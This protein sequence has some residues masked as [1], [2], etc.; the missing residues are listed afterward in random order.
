MRYR[1]VLL[2]ALSALLLVLAACAP[3]PIYK[4]APNAVAATPAQVASSPERYAGGPVI[5]G[6][7]IVEVKNLADHS[8]IQV[9]S[10]PLDNS[11]RP[12]GGHGDSSG[13]GRFIALV[14]GY[15]EAMNYPAGAMITISG[16]L[17]GSRAGTVGEAS[18]V[19]PLVDAGQSHVWTAE[20]MRSGHPNI[21]F[22]VGVGVIR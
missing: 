8:E 19:F 1:L 3:A 21:S 6:G 22:G 13:N 11:Q 15:V 2:P 20:E 14:P 18:Y 10:Y 12:N 17:K 5:W 7:R 16:N 4:A 9:L